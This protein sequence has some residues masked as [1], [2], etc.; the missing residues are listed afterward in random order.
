MNLPFINA[1]RRQRV[2]HEHRR[3]R[4]RPPRGHLDRGRA[5]AAEAGWLLYLAAPAAGS[6]RRGP[7]RARGRDV[8]DHPPRPR[9]PGPDR[10]R[11]PRH[12]GAVERCATSVGLDRP[13]PEQFARYIAHAAAGDFG[14]SFTLRTRRSANWSA[15]AVGAE[16]DPDRLRD[17]GGAGDRRAAGDRRGACGPN[18]VVDNAIR[19]VT[20]LTFAMPPFW[21]GLM[22]A[23]VF[24]LEL[25]LVPGLGLRAG[26]RRH[27]ADADAAGAHARPRAPGGRRAHAALEPA[28]GAAERVHR[29]G[30]VARAAASC[31]SSASTRCATRSC[32]RS[33]SSSVNIGFLIGGTVVLEQVFQI[34]GLGSLLLEAVAEQRLPAGP[35]AGAAGRRGGRGRR[36]C[37]RTCCRP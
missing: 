24:G 32:P 8:P 26:H 7:V 35:G 16:R 14:T 23:L 9:R 28:R 36:A 25:E 21:L 27:P 12:A 30:A 1:H 3:A 13:L 22:L 6:E 34:P 10:A 37:W 15:A 5:D 33:R 19:L 11:G 20:T 17:A 18:G 2:R 29:G 31:A 4:V